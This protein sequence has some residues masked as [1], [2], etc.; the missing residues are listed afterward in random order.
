MPAQ[1]VALTIVRIG[2]ATQFATTLLLV[3]LFSL[4]RSQA[5]RRGYFSYWAWGWAMLSLGLAALFVRFF[6]LGG[7][8]AVEGQEGRAEQILNGVYQLGKL[9]FIAGVI[10]GTLDY[11]RGIRGRLIFRAGLVVAL[12]YALVSVRF[13]GSLAATMV[14]QVPLTAGG[15]LASAVVLLRLPRSRRSLGSRFTGLVLAVFGVTWLAYTFVFTSPMLPA[16]LNFGNWIRQISLYN[17]HIDLMMQMLLAYGMIL[18]LLEDAKRE[19]EAAHTELAVAHQE[20][21]A[22][23]LRDS[24]TRALNRRAY[25]EGAGLEVARAG[26]GTVIVFDLDNLKDVNDAHGHKAGDRL[27]QY[28]VDVLRPHLRPTDKLFRFGGDE[29]LLV[30]PRADRESVMTRFRELLTDVKP[31]HIEE[32]GEAVELVPRVSMGASGFEG[33]EQL[34]AAVTRADREMYAEKRQHKLFES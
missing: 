14:W 34:D 33:G 28:F 30:M 17:A 22:E 31:L 8:V 6:Y 19:T 20:L 15:F 5:R 27:L 11:T 13:A 29:F 24:L 1:D 16:L 4:L 3:L 23:S 32:E 18:I 9:G 26:F 21:K 2:L 7:P 10:A 25:N 12:L